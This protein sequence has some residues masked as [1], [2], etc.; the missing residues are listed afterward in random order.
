VCRRRT[1]APSAR[2]ARRLCDKAACA[3]RSKTT[4]PMKK[5]RQLRVCRRRTRVPSAR[6]ARSLRDA[7]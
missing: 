3:S 2:R 1:K 4:W 5:A 6:E 7:T